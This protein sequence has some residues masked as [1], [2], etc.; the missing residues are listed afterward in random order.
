LL[1]PLYVV[2]GLTVMM[3]VV[4]WVLLPET[5]HRGTAGSRAKLSP[6]DARITPILLMSFATFLCVSMHNQSFGFYLQDLLG[7]KG[8]E[9]ARNTGFGYIA[10]GIAAIVS[11]GIVVQIVKPLPLT[12]LRAGP[13]I[14]GVGYAVLLA[15]TSI[16]WIVVAMAIAG[17]GTGLLQAGIYSAGSLRVTAEEQGA[18]AGLLG[19]APAAGFLLGPTLSASLYTANHQF[20]FM[21]IVAVFA[22][23]AVASWMLRSG[24]PV[25]PTNVP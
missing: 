18:V 13:A 7:T 20:P 5:V 19:A 6:L 9:T 25:A 22:T 16:T 10:V 24:K 15:A 14:A 21:A 2:S 4:A 1:L 12:L 11:Q 8:P 23:L 3:G 17:F